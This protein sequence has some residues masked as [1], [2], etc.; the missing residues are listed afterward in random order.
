MTEVQVT[1]TPYLHDQAAYDAAADTQYQDFRVGL[2]AIIA[3]HA[4]EL[5]KQIANPET[6]D[7]LRLVRVG[8]DV[9]G[10]FLAGIDESIRQQYNCRTCRQFFNGYGSGVLN[11]R[12]PSDSIGVPY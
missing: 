7:V 3:T 1:T 8:G 4:Q 10:N 5:S 12:P 9:F 2:N 11:K 6:D